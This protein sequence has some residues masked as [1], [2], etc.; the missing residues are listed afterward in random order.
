MRWWQVLS[1]L[2]GIL[3]VLGGFLWLLD[4]VFRLYANIALWSPLVANTF[5][6]LVILI[7]VGA[8]GVALY[9]FGV[10][11]RPRRQRQRPTA[12]REKTAAAAATLDALEQQVAQIQDSVARQALEA[13]SRQLGA[14]MDR[15]DLHIAVF[16]VGSTGKTAL[17]NAVIGEPVGEVGAPMGTTQVEKPYRL[18]F[19]GLPW[20]VVLTDTPGIAEAGSAGALREQD[21]RRIATEADLLLFVVEDDLRQSEFE[22]VQLLLDMGKRLIVVLN[23]IDRYPDADREAIL[24]RIRERLA[25]RLS[26]EDVVPAAANPQPIPLE[27]GDWVRMEPEVTPLLVR[28]AEVLRQEGAT[29]IADNIL[30]KSQQL[31]E[32]ARRLIDQ[33][34]QAQ[35]EAMVERYQWIVAGVVA[36]MPLPG[37]D[38]LATAAVN[39][40]MVVELGRLYGCDISLEE[41]KALALSLAKTL[42]GLGIVKGTMELLALGLQTNLATVL[43]GR[44]L[45]GVSAAYLTRIAGKSFIEYFRHSQD[46]GDGGMGEVVQEQFRLNQRDA[47]VKAFVSEALSVVMPSIQSQ[48]RRKPEEFPS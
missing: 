33:Q 40:Q 9:Y 14:A 29:L 17:V 31:Q 36:A 27:G 20:G 18:V 35:A 3:F 6:G 8:I 38:L 2:I 43:V 10:F 37:I 5:L 23:K 12:P 28:M 46:W 1:I 45:Q 32:T 21:A 39:A 7:I 16:G 13:E 44:A 4:T 42:T 22:V 11:L 19:E 34:R 41:G 30:L 25:F 47:F 26:P 48:N 24:T 15:Q